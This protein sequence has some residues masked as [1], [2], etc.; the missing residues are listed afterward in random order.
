MEEKEKFDF[1]K[2]LS[3]HDKDDNYK[4]LIQI[5][6]TRSFFDII[7]KGRSETMHSAFIAWLLGTKE[8]VSSTGELSPL[9]SFLDLLLSRCDQVQDSQVRSDIMSALLSK[10]INHVQIE[11]EKA[12]KI[13]EKI[14]NGGKTTTYSTTD[15]ADVFIT[16]EVGEV[17]YLILIEN[18]VGSVEEGPKEKIDNPQN[19]IESYKSKTQTDR[20]HAILTNEDWN[21]NSIPYNDYKNHK[22]IFVFLTPFYDE[23]N[24]Y[25]EKGREVANNKYFIN[26]NY[27]DLLDYC[28][29]PFAKSTYISDKNR[30]F[31]EEYIKCLSLSS[32]NEE[33]S[34][35]NY[36]VMASTADEKD[37]LKNYYEK[38]EPL[39]LYAVSATNPKVSIEG[40]DK[41]DED[42]IKDNSEN[43]KLFYERNKDL[44]MV[45]LK[46]CNP[47]VYD[48]LFRDNTKFC[49]TDEKGNPNSKWYG[50]GQFYYECVKRYIYKNKNTEIQHFESLFNHGIGDGDKTEESDYPKNRLNVVYGKEEDGKIKICESSS[51][52]QEGDNVVCRDSKSI[53]SFS[54]D[55]SQKRYNKVPIK[56]NDKDKSG[57]FVTTQWGDGA[58]HTFWEWAKKNIGNVKSNNDKVY[59]N[60]NNNNNN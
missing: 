4:K 17:K 55:L 30:F 25:P 3:K 20:Y 1:A 8:L 54:L 21:K 15:K 24:E 40:W 49:S 36:I 18:K 6:S 39:I 56:L 14:T 47:D 42:A 27:Q 59:P 51:Y 12:L 10:S 23:E 45:A 43:L 19:A 46:E 53:R 60:N 48:T 13:E 9:R 38:N 7:G 50:K 35:K 28:I 11:T 26:I 52:K 2:A 33:K 22:K 34:T 32:V 41:D 37:E 57:F 29:L 58:F 16:F 31:L 44:I 5:Y